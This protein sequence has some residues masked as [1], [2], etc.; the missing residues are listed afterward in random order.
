MN[1][2]NLFTGDIFGTL[3][4]R[5]SNQILQIRNIILTVIGLDA[6]R[7]DQAADV[8]LTRDA[9][10]LHK[11]IVA[12]TEHGKVCCFS[13]CFVNSVVNDPIFQIFGIDNMSGK[14]HWIK[15]LPNFKSFNDHQSL[16]IF[17]QRTSRHF[18]N[19]PMCVIVG[20]N[21]VKVIFSLFAQAFLF[22][23]LP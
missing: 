23:V 10:G 14:Y 16:K 6:H 9:F 4:R 2:R 20:K 8:D 5:I 15:H 3:L 22:V 21:K 19:P 17:V 12:V 13:L 1:S 7:P 18:P 11:M